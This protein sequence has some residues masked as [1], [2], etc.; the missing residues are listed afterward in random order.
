[1]LKAEDAMIF[2]DWF[3]LSP[4]VVALH[5]VSLYYIVKFDALNRL[6]AAIFIV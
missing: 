5:P 2:P 4:G 3:R 6:L 1:M